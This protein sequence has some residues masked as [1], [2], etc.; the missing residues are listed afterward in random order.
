MIDIANSRVITCPYCN[1][2]IH[3]KENA[4]K[5]KCEYCR[6]FIDIEPETPEK[7]IIEKNNYYTIPPAPVDTAELEKLNEE[8]KK[9]RK[10]WI[11]ACGVAVIATFVL[12][13][14]SGFAT[15]RS[16]SA[17]G[18]GICGM[19]IFIPI[20]SGFILG[21]TKPLSPVKKQSGGRFFAGMF[22]F[23][24]ANG[25]YFTGLISSA[26]VETFTKSKD[27]GSYEDMYSD[28]NSISEDEYYSE[29]YGNAEEEFTEAEELFYA[30]YLVV[31][32]TDYETY[33]VLFVEDDKVMEAGQM[34]EEVNSSAYMNGY[35][36]E[37]LL[38]FYVEQEAPH[39]SGTYESDPEASMYFATFA[40]QSDA[41]EMADIIM[42]FVEYPDELAEFVERYGDDI[43]WE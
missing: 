5:V 27:A 1:A 20:I 33:L 2:V 38:D 34:A 12:S 17:A 28:L 24:L 14:V 40:N 37:A 4:K 9:K 32:P 11:R 18:M 25:A 39:L 29:S 43:Q 42:N 31:E 41:E 30:E 19:S 15:F 7:I 13:F 10:K 35:N 3:C 36:W 6:S 21:R 22:V 8:F 23:V 16:G 26:I